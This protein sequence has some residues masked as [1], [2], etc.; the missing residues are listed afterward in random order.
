M[1][2]EAL[3]SLK[4]LRQFHRD[5]LTFL[6]SL[7]RS[8][9]RTRFALGPWTVYLLNDP[10]SVRTVLTH[11]RTH[12]TK[13]PGMNR[14][15]PLIGRGLLTE[16]GDSWANQRRRLAPVF[17]PA[18]VTATV[19]WLDAAIE[20]FLRDVVEGQPFNLESAMLTLSLTMVLTSVFAEEPSAT[21]INAMADDIRWLMAHFYHRSRS[22][23][24]FPYHIPPFNR[25]YHRHA[26]HLK[27][28]FRAGLPTPRPFDTAWPKFSPDAATGDQESMTLLAA[29]YETTGHAIAWALDLLSRHP[30]PGDLVYQ[31]SQQPGVPTP[32]THP[33]TEAVVKEA[34]RLYPPVWLLSRTP[35]LDITIDTLRLKP[36][37]I[38]LI[39]PWVLHRTP[40]WF[41]LPEQ[42][43]PDR[44]LSSE[45]EPY[46]Y[47]PFGGG[48]RRC[49]GEGLALV[50]ARLA[51]SRIWR[52]FQLI[53]H[54]PRRLNP[55]LTLGCVDPMW[56][57]AVRRSPRIAP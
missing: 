54:G 40:E 21:S 45:P 11:H 41:S 2:S 19:P 27:A 15:N 44:W 42:F 7:A 22:I 57:T 31:E 29:G 34:L 46:S 17:R 1:T 18:N 38:V 4:R 28:N 56:V 30:K 52:Q 25:R 10:H 35:I 3:A 9:P 55:Q 47:I 33:Y 43:N 16:E 8:G 53:S 24:R 12:F 51:V 14:A 26:H 50:E 49:I 23:W 48:A 5:P 32:A 36:H 20:S 37:D 39:S 6:A 13:G